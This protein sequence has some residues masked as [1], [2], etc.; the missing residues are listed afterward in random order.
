MFNFDAI[1]DKVLSTIPEEHYTACYN[2]AIWSNVVFV[3]FYWVHGI[4]WLLIAK[5]NL[6]RQ[7]KIQQKETPQSGWD[8]VAHLAVGHLVTFPILTWFLCVYM[9]PR[10]GSTWD[11]FNIISSVGYIVL[12]QLVFDTYFYWSHRAF[13]TPFLYKRIHKKHHQYYVTVSLAAGYAH[14]IEDLIVNLGSTLCG[15]LLFPHHAFT[16]YIYL[17]MRMHETIDAHCG[18]DFPLSIW[19]YLPF[20]GGPSRHDWHHAHNMGNYGGFTWWDSW[21]GTD[22][23]YLKWKERQKE[24]NQK[25]D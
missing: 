24:R 5:L 3:L 18:Y 17:A 8:L 9:V 12:Y 23:P 21:C 19:K 16:Y 10:M 4:I 20:H 25:N 15:P 7:W 14:P 1:K 6:F 11:D 13:H 2:F 22:K